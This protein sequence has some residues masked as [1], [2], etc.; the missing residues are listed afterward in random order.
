MDGERT[1]LRGRVRAAGPNSRPAVEP[2]SASGARSGETPGPTVQSGWE[3][4]GSRAHAAPEASCL[5]EECPSSGFVWARSRHACRAPKTT[6]G[7]VASGDMNT[8]QALEHPEEAPRRHRIGRWQRWLLPAGILA[9]LAV[10]QVLTST[11]IM[12][13]FLLPRRPRSPAGSCTRGATSP[14]RTTPSSR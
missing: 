9:A 10:W 3:K 14:W 13:P 1:S 4:A 12:P 11:A 6:S 7:R 2:A 8:G 5:P